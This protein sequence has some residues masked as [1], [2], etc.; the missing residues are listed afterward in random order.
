MY[1]DLGAAGVDLGGLSDF[2]TLFKNHGP[3]RG[4]R[5]ATG[6]EFRDNL[7]FGVKTPPD[8]TAGFYLYDEDGRRREPRGPKPTFTRDFSISCTGTF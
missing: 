7:D 8:G 2:D 3:R 5:T 4:D 6:G 1:R